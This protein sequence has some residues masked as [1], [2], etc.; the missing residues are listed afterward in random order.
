MIMEKKIV[1]FDL[2]D[3]VLNDVSVDFDRGLKI[4]WNNYFTKACTYDEMACYGEELFRLMKEQQKSNKEVSFVKD[5]VPLYFKKFGVKPVLLTEYEEW[6]VAEA[7]NEEI[8]LPEVKETL[9]ILKNQGDLM[10]ILS[11][12]IFSAATLKKL[13]EKYGAENYF[14]KVWS[15]ADF[16]KRKPDIDFFNYVINQII[17]EN[18]NIVKKDI[19]YVGNSYKYDVIGGTNAGLKTVWLNVDNEPNIYD[20]SVT[21]I[22]AINKL[23]DAIRNS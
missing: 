10:Y 2:F 7:I 14:S 11:N 23:L 21:I 16:G 19:I 1:I 3:T 13:L 8:L 4:L 17:I 9:E 22:D 6:Q 5:E 20:I 18:P 15:S 12:S